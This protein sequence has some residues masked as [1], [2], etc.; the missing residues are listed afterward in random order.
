MFFSRERL[1]S[2][3]CMVKTMPL[4]LYVEQ[5]GW[6]AIGRAIRITNGGRDLGLGQIPKKK[7]T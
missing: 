1:V 6:E 4:E 2:G 5:H 3:W 7:Q